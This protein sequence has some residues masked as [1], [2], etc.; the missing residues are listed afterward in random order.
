MALI[1]SF[2]V[3]FLWKLISQLFKTFSYWHFHITFE[4]L[5][6]RT[7][8]FRIWRWWWSLQT[9]SITLS[10]LNW[11]RSSTHSIPHQSSYGTK[12]HYNTTHHSKQKQIKS[13][14]HLIE[15]NRRHRSASMDNERQLK[16]IYNN[17]GAN[18]MNVI[19]TTSNIILFRSRRKKY[20]LKTKQNMVYSKQRNFSLFPF[21]IATRGKFNL[22]FCAS[23]IHFVDIFLS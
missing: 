2:F 9:R 5:S 14:R 16:Y 20:A 17:I 7:Q 13:N 3:R 6:Q 8:A 15:R 21:S 10:W 23:K 1:L 4:F 18:N 12:S 22:L 11:I 19:K